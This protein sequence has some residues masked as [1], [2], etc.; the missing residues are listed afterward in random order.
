MIDPM[1]VRLGPIPKNKNILIIPALAPISDHK[2][3]Y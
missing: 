2:V 3:N 1:R